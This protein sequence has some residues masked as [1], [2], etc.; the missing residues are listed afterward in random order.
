G[1]ALL[2]WLGILLGIATIGATRLT[3]HTACNA[4]ADLFAEMGAGAELEIAA[5][6]RAAFD[7]SFAPGPAAGPAVRAVVPRVQGVVALVG[8]EQRLPLPVV[9]ADAAHWPVIDGESLSGANDAWL[10]P[11][12][13]GALGVKPGDR[14]RAWAPTGL[15]ELRL[16]GI[17]RPAS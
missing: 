7:G 8:N 6:G 15:T 1:R 17:V 9:G 2:T 11:G 10:D 4:Y 5:S 14:L 13:A 16:A 12:T 3:V